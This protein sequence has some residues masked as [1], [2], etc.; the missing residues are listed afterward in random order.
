MH[1]G[2]AMVNALVISFRCSSRTTTANKSRQPQSLPLCT[3]NRFSHQPRIVLHTE[4]LVSI[5]CLDLSN[6]CPVSLPA[7]RA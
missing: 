7:Q 2:W 4:S 3:T 1:N 6:T 5:H